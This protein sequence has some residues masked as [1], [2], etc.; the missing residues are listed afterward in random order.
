M[1]T[2]PRILD[3]TLRDGSYVVDFQFT[4]ED[5]ATVAAALESAGIDLIEIGHGLGLNASQAGKGRA[6]ASDEAYLRAASQTLRH[7]KW[8]MFFI[9]GIGRLED[10]DLARRHGMH[11][12]RIGANAPEIASTRE[13]VSHARALGFE[14]AVNLMKSYSVPPDELA[15]CAALAESFGAHVVSLVDSA[16]TMLPDDVRTY[17]RKMRSTLSVP[18]GFHGHDNLSLAMA[19]VLAALEAG[20]E[21]VDT[22]LQG[23]GRSGGNA[24]TE[25]L[26]AILFKQGLA[27]RVDLNRL[28]D[29]SERIVRP[30]L[31]GKGHDPI[32]I[33]AGYAGFHSSYLA[34]V[35]KHA[36]RC[37]IDPRELIVEVSGVD[38][39]EV[40]EPLVQR[41]ADDIRARQ[42]GR[43]GTHVVELPHGLDDK[44]GVAGSL[45]DAV[46]HA[47]RQARRRD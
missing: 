30:L 35:F 42:R 10:L 23:I 39:V 44:A 22:T 29:V 47:A 45:T 2:V 36:E 31:R 20:A 18:V 9:P 38:R 40:T 32:D 28:M 19:N 27:P 15:R 5:T 16:G 14:V 8:G 21:V 34:L 6:A 26:V 24:V 46:R 11:F 41:I 1:S 12:V 43:S 7:A 17:V 37:Q 33:T 4:A 25:I 13:Y 3:C